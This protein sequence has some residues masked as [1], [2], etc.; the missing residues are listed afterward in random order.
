MRLHKLLD[1]DLRT[2]IDTSRSKNIKSV[3]D[4]IIYD[5]MDIRFP[6]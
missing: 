2:K 6:V 5:D 1:E 3:K 4:N